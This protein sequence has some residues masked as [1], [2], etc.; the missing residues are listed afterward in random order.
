MELRRRGLALRR[1]TRDFIAYASFNYRRSEFD[2]QGV[3]VAPWGDLD[4]YKADAHVE[5]NFGG[6]W[7]VFADGGVTAGAEKNASLGDGLTGHAAAGAKY[8]FSPQ[9]SY[10]FGVMAITRLDES[11][12][13]LPMT[14]FDIRF[15]RWS[16]RTLNGLIVSYDACGDGSLV[17]DVSALY[18]NPFFRLTNDPVTGSGRVV[19]FQE[20]PVSFGVTKSLGENAFVRGYITTIAWSDYRFHS[21][22]ATTGDFLDLA[23]AAFRPLGRREILNRSSGVS[24]EGSRCCLTKDF[25]S[26]NPCAG[27]FS[28][29]RFPFLNS[30]R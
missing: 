24:P 22:D 6:D 26:R 28:A 13:I 5:Y 19:E 20:V 16:A 1:V 8:V 7:W 18:D 14:S 25:L 30:Q 12:L 23:G 2:F 3:P 21:N 4:S 29:E 17:S 10:Y 9:F 11:T 27:R 15:G